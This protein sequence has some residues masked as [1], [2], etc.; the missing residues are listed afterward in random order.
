MKIESQVCS[1]EL[2]R[3]LKEPGV[4]RESFFWWVLDMDAWKLLDDDQFNFVARQVSEKKGRV[5]PEHYKAF[6][7]A[8]LGQLLPK[9]V[10][11]CKDGTGFRVGYAMDP[12]PK[13][14]MNSDMPP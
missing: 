6:G 12:D 3:R 14:P 9:W 1:L 5:M 2:S 4:N 7:V 10:Y 11:I 8:E 13:R